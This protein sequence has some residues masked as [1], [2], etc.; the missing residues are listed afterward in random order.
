LCKGD[1]EPLPVKIEEK[2]LVKEKGYDAEIELEK[3]FLIVTIETVAYLRTLKCL[4]WIHK[5]LDGWFSLL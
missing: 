5:D 2:N 1:E 3:N 4:K